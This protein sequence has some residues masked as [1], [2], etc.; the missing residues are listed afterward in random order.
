MLEPLI[1]REN[2]VLNAIASLK[3]EQRFT[4]N[5]DH[6]AVFGHVMNMVENQHTTEPKVIFLDGPGGTG[7]TYLSN[8]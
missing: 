7:K 1:V 2:L 3:P 4:F 5:Q 8:A 6:Q